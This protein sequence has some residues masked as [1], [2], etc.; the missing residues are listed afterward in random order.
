MIADWT[1]EVG[2]E[3]PSIEVPWSGWVDLHAYPELASGLTEARLY[4]ELLGLLNT[5]NGPMLRTSKVDV[6]PVS[7]EEVDP[8]IAETGIEATAW[9]L[10]NY[11]DCLP[12]CPRDFAACEQIARA[13]AARLAKIELPLAAA[14]IVIRPARLYDEDAFGWT[15]YAIGFGVSEAQARECW[16]DAARSLLR[17]FT[18]CAA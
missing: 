13:V 11:L 2:P 15:L 4:P 10:G 17:V 14:E 6:F 18:E 12:V 16:A 8:E 9:G 1:V 7:R 3:C 5:A